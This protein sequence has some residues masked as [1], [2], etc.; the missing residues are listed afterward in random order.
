MDI[1]STNKKS[2]E[3]IKKNTSLMKKYSQLLHGL[4]IEHFNYIKVYNDGRYLHLVDD[5]Q[6]AEYYVSNIY[7]CS[8]TAIQMAFSGVN[9]F[10]WPQNHSDFLLKS[11][12]DYNMAFGYTITIF[13]D[14]CYESFSFMTNPENPEILNVYLQNARS[15]ERFVYYFLEKTRSL[16]QEGEKYLAHFQ[17][18]GFDF[19]LIQKPNQNILDLPFIHENRE[20]RLSQKEKECLGLFSKGYGM[21]DIGRQ[22]QISHRTVESYIQ[23]IKTKFDVHYKAD[24]ANIY[25]K[26]M[27]GFSIVK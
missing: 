2:L 10:L 15:L 8:P 12:W 14:Q 20:V 6:W 23:N 16:I 4:G 7:T 22:L 21:K 27:E 13:S 1:F 24:L 19:S 25:W 17:A 5:E 26:N 9:H 3:F 18:L 11:A